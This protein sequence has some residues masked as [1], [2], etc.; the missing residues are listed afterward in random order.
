[1]ASNVFNI[2]A[3]LILKTE[4]FVETKFSVFCFELLRYIDTNN[5]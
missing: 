5:I 4:N 2:I 1:M 3:I